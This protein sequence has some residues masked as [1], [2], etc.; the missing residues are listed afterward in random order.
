M[1]SIQILVHTVNLS[2]LWLRKFAITSKAQSTFIAIFAGLGGTAVLR[3]INRAHVI[4]W[5][6]D[7][8]KR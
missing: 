8:E 6:K 5:R 1:R 2:P 4:T 7:L 3:S